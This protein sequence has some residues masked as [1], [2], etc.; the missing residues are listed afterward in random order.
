MG[1]YQH[2]QTKLSCQLIEVSK[3]RVIQNRSYEKHCICTDG[4]GLI[5]LVFLYH[6]V[7]SQNGQLALLS[8]LL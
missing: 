7:L 8:N 2:I 3:L 5:E 6:E 4:F 1:L